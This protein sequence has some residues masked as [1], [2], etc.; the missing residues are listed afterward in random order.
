MKKTI[1][2]F[3]LCFCQCLLAALAFAACRGGEHEPDEE[4]EEREQ[5]TYVQLTIRSGNHYAT[6]AD[7]P[8]GGENQEGEA[9]SQHSE[10]KVYNATILLYQ[11]ANGINAT[12]SEAKQIRIAYAFYAPTMKEVSQTEYQSPLLHDEKIHIQRGT[13]HVL[14]VVNMGDMTHCAGRTLADVRDLT[15]LGHVR[16]SDGSASLADGSAPDAALPGLPWQGRSQQADT[17]DA[18]WMTSSA[19]CIV[20]FGGLDGP[21][22]PVQVEASVSRLA[23]RIDFSPGDGEY[24]EA[25]LNFTPMGESGAVTVSRYYKYAI[26][27]GDTFI[28]TGWCP[29]NLRQDECY[30]FRRVSDYNDGTHIDYLGQEKAVNIGTESQPLWQQTNYVIDPLTAKKDWTNASHPP[31]A[32]FFNRKYHNY[33]YVAADEAVDAERLPST[34]FQIQGPAASNVFYTLGYAVENTLRNDSPKERYATGIVLKGYYRKNDGTYVNKNYVYYIR[35]SDP[36]NSNSE[37]LVMKY[38]I[39]RNN[40]YR[41]R[42]GSVSQTGIIVLEAMNWINIYAD[43][44]YL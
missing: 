21:E 13:Y 40:V 24:S 3:L 37:A 8:Q 11:S 25:P 38:G 36:T 6:R 16:T 26:S 32:D 31:T 22:H 15:T 23:A 44:I 19:D 4:W 34:A 35:H 9:E 39:V 12:A 20:S 10:S 27:N 43:D 2:H 29:I 18:F 1:L 30:L 14:V 17:Y 5:G 7:G 33:F 41:V 28:L 42:V